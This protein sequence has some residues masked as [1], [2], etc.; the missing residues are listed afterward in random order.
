MG[1]ATIEEAQRLLERDGIHTVECAFPDSWGALRGK[2]VPA[3]QFPRVAE[4]GFALA[5]ACYV[6]DLTCEIFPIAFANPD[7]GYPDMVAIPD[8]STLRPLTWREGTAIVMCDTIDHR[9]HEPIVL[10]PRHLLRTVI[11][12]L[13][14]AGYEPIAATELEF[15]L[16]TED[17]QPVDDIIDCYSIPKGAQFEG[18][19]SDVRRKME[20]FGIVVEACNMEY[21]PGQV[22][23]NLGH[24]P[25]LG[26]ADDT[27]LFKYAV[28]EIARQHGLRATFMA[29]PFPVHSGN[30]MHVHLS[31]RDGS[32]QNAFDVRD[33]DGGGPMTSSL[34][35]RALAGLLAHQTELTAI[36]APT[37][38][39]YRRFADYSFAP[40]AVT[41]GLDNRQVAVRTLVDSG[42]ATRIE[43]RG[44]SADSNP[45][46]VLAAL[47]AAVHDGLEHAYPVPPMTEGD[48]YAP[49]AGEP[50]PAS[51]RESIH[52]LEH[53]RLLRGAL[54]DVFVDNFLDLLR[55]EVQAFAGQVTEWEKTRYI[56]VA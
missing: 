26:V 47:L 39:A 10:D 55:H 1:V 28:K 3:S 25:A 49:G 2:R 21:G 54:G 6:W 8:L 40:T 14:S 19:L 27:C 53:G 12:R 16:C 13:Q 46:L 52:A 20:S 44:G 56:E 33:L 24:G 29:K 4:K 37:I 15:Y 5:N 45:P 41:W 35:Q 31:L 23:V 38:N 42:A 9:T 48:A 34:M 51:L 30:G 50:L 43:A 11:G 17:W 36:N 32:G 7:T 18:V 22:E